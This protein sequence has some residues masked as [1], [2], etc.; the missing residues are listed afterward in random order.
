MKLA[1]SPAYVG[2]PTWSKTTFILL[3][4]FAFLSIVLTKLLPY[5]E[6]NQEVL[7]IIYCNSLPLNSFLAA[8]SKISLSPRS[9]VFPYLFKGFSVSQ[10]SFTGRTEPP[11]T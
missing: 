1:K 10:S 2:E 7:I 3:C 4:C 11:N 5:S 8:V 9:L 6:Y